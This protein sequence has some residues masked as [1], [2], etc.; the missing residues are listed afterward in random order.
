MK[1]DLALQTYGADSSGM[2]CGFRF[3]PT[4]AGRP[5]D[6]DEVI[7][8]FRESEDDADAT[9]KDGG[10]FLWLHFNLAH[11]ASERWMRT[12]LDRKRSIKDALPSR[13]RRSEARCPRG[14]LHT[15]TDDREQRP[16]EP[17]G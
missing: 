5:I 6:A 17:S 2:V 11:S 9:A 13:G 7:D 12:Q 8:W 10:E 1:S 15:D 3:L 4:L 14:H 16:E